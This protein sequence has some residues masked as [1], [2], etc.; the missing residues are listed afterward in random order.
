MVQIHSIFVPYRKKI[1]VNATRLGHPLV[2]ALWMHYPAD[3]VAQDIGGQFLLGD[4]FL[5]A[6]ALDAGVATVQVYLPAG[7]W[8]DAWSGNLSTS[9][10]GGLNMTVP[11]PLGFPPIFYRSD[12]ADG[13]AVRAGLVQLDSAACV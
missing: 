11:A 5:V 10:A 8:V 7:S 3:P 13:A 2:R 4:T 12:S 6:P 1:L 9:P